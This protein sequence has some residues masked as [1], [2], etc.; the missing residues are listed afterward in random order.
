MKFEKLMIYLFFVLQFL[1]CGTPNIDN[2]TVFEPNNNI[3]YLDLEEIEL[4]IW[5]N[6]YRVENGIEPLEADKLFNDVASDRTI[7]MIQDGECSHVGFSDAIQPIVSM[8]FAA[9][10]NI[11]YGFSTNESVYKAF[12]NSEEHRKNILRTDWIYTGI[13]IQEDENGKKYYCQI[14]VRYF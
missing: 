4:F 8:G 5:I 12:I 14:F 1:Y 7:R 6:D 11:A 2:K 13:S 3:E 9:G 10:E